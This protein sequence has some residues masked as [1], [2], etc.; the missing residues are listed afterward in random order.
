[1][2]RYAFLLNSTWKGQLKNVQDGISRPVGS[3]DIQKT[4]VESVLWDT[5]SINA[6]NLLFVIFVSFNPHQKC[7]EKYLKS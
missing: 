7:K 4:K 1:M 6:V 3:R 2:Q 5:C